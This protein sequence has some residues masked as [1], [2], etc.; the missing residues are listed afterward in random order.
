[1]QHLKF[2]G[3]LV[4]AIISME[5]CLLDCNAL[6]DRRFGIFRTGST[7]FGSPSFWHYYKEPSPLIVLLSCHFVQ[8]FP[9]MTA[10][11]IISLELEASFF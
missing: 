6:H 3:Q 7:F 1:M 10:L 2:G 8:A 4:L 9:R 11:A 5:Y